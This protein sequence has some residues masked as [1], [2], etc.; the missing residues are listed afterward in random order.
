MIPEGSP[1]ILGNNSP[2]EENPITEPEIEPETSWSIGNFAI[3]QQS[4]HT[5]Y[6]DYL[7]YCQYCLNETWK[8]LKNNKNNKLAVERKYVA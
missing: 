5:L 2:L 7:F 3:I 6:I 4:T 8:Y 1:Y